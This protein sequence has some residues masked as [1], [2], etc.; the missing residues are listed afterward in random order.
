M[1]LTRVHSEKFPFG[2]RACANINLVNCECYANNGPHKLCCVKKIKN[3]NLLFGKRIIF[4]ELLL[5]N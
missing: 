2:E 4:L 1:Y 5:D 3:K